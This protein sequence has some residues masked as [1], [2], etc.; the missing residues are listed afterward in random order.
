VLRKLQRFPGAWALAVPGR[1]EVRLASPPVEA[2]QVRD[3]ADAAVSLA[4]A[5]EAD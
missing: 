1:V 4:D 3:A 2:A 5:L